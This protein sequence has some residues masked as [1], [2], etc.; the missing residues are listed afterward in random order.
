VKHTERAEQGH[1]GG[2]RGR[3][4]LDLGA[5]TFEVIGAT[6]AEREA[7]D[8]AGAAA[9]H[10]AIG[11]YQMHRGAGAQEADREIVCRRRSLR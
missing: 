6:A 7:L 11:V 5:R 2:I 3:I 10:A 8:L 1:R 9:L 4:L